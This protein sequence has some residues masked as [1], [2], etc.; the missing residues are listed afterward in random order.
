M[1]F[2]Q[3]NNWIWK[4][5]VKSVIINNK[6]KQNKQ[7]TQLDWKLK[8]TA[9]V[10]TDVIKCSSPVWWVWLAWC[11]HGSGM[12]N[13]AFKNSF[14][15][16]TRPLLPLI[17]VKFNLCTYAIVFWFWQPFG[18][19]RIHTSPSIIS[20]GRRIYRN[21]WGLSNMV[22]QWMHGVG[23]QH[24]VKHSGVWKIL[25]GE[26]LLLCSHGSS[27][28]VTS[29]CWV[30]AFAMRNIGVVSVNSLLQWQHIH[31]SPRTFRAYQEEVMGK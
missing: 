28:T 4:T 19:R 15:L 26:G 14:Y 2:L 6:T 20:R 23:K 9:Q 25:F 1:W 13:H 18:Y 3:Q 8:C 29:Q 24:P 10:Q 16:L 31:H 17:G 21:R 22:D 5:V 12:K 30:I 27:Q 11:A 7:T